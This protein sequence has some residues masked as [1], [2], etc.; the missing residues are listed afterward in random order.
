MDMTD[1]KSIAAKTTHSKW[2]AG[3][4]LGACCLAL[5]GCV[6]ET[7]YYE[8]T[9]TYY[10][11]QHYRP[12]A[13]A[14][15]YDWPRYERPRYERPQYVRPRYEPPRYDRTRFDRDDRQP[16]R[17]DRDGRPDREELRPRGEG[18]DTERDQRR[19]RRVWVEDNG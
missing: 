4:L 8:T 2:G 11:T 6:S 3:L 14:P 9:P 19:P 12:Y 15:R 10:R 16:S 13:P 17:I 7:G 5:T 18:R 1:M